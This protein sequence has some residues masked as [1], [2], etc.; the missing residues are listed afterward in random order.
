MSYDSDDRTPHDVR[1]GSYESG[2][3][4]AV[5]GRW[6][7][8]LSALLLALGLGLPLAGLGALADGRPLEFTDLM[9]FRTI[10]APVISEDGAWVAYGLW[11]D[12]GDGAAVVRSTTDG[13]EYVIERGSAPLI[14]PDGRWVAAKIEPP[15]AEQEKKEL[16]KVCFSHFNTQWKFLA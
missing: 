13:D 16:E 12:R 3:S 9:R 1:A 14:S 4:L 8:S 5:R 11:P 10:R 2:V 7:A 6:R 15:L